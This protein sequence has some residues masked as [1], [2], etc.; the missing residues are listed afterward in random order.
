M[1]ATETY[2]YDRVVDGFRTWDAR[3]AF[4]PIPRAELEASPSLL[5]QNTGY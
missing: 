5:P 1:P 3:K 2:E 4:L